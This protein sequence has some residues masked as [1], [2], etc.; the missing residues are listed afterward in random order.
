MIQKNMEYLIKEFTEASDAYNNYLKKFAIDPNKQT[1]VI[2]KALT[3]EDVD[4]MTELRKRRDELEK[5]VGMNL[6]IIK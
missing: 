2:E 4:I 5:N 1:N 6:E 3:K